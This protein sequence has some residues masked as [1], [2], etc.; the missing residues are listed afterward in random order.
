VILDL[1]GGAADPSRR[2]HVAVLSAAAAAVALALLM[3]LSVPGP[4]SGAPPMAA[5]AAPTPTSLTVALASASTTWVRSVPGGP[6]E[7]SLRDDVI[8]AMCAAGIGLNSPVHH[9]V[10]DREGRPIAAYTSGKTGRFI[11]LPQTYVGSGWLPVPCDA[12]D[13]FAPRINRAR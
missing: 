8:G 13:V 4:R 11:A 10:F 9:L 5:S 2:G 12:S 3:V 6:F 7:E 1:D